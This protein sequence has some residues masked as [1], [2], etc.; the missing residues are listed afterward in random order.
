MTLPLA[1]RDWTVSYAVWAT[2]IF[3]VFLV[4]ELMPVF[5]SGCPWSTLSGTAQHAERTYPWLRVIVFGF[6]LGLLIHISFEIK[7]A[8]ALLF[9]YA[10]T[11]LIHFLRFRYRV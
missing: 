1:V 10:F 6:L 2:L 11:F 9:A 8:P 3:V 5:W 7:M 4:F